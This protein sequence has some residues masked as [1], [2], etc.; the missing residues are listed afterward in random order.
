MD[1]F[2]NWMNMLNGIV[3]GP[4]MIILL[5]GTGLYLTLRLGFV[6]V[7]YL[8][9][10][11]RCVSGKYDD[12]KEQGDVTH[13]QALCSALSATIGTG[14]IAG[15]ATAITLGGP[16]AVFWMWV[17]ALVG[18]AT[19]YT[20]CSLAIRYRIIHEDGS[21]SGGPMYFLE[22]GLNLK[23]LGKCFA[24]FAAA[25]AF[26]AGCTV[27]SNSVA[28]GLLMIM[29]T[30]V[31]DIK[32]SEQIPFL[33]GIV[34]LKP[35]IGLIIAI[36][37]G[38]VIIGGIKRIANVASKIV[39]MMCVVYIVGAMFILFKNIDMV[40]AAF[41]QIF[42]YA[43]NPLATGAGVVGAVIAMTLKSGVARG[44]FS[45]ESGL[46]S[47]PIAHA[48][49]KTHEM[50][51]EGM[52]AMLGP[53]IDTII[54]CTMTALVII[55]SGVWQ[56][57]DNQGNVLYGPNG[58][59]LPMLHTV[60][61]VNMQVV[62]SLD[63]NRQ[64]ILDE[65][66]QPYILPTGAS[67]TASAFEKEIPGFGQWIVVF[68]LVFFAYSSM[69]AWSYYGDRSCEYLLGE[70]SVTPYRYLFCFFAFIGPI[71]GLDL[72]WIIADNLN[73]LMAIPNLIALILLSKV[74]SRETKD[75]IK[76]MK[77]IHDM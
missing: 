39:P 73:A 9:H 6:Q 52:V 67:M 23:W 38:V 64:P 27:Q 59:G 49:A 72:I 77:E 75:Y 2:S 19:K 44:I 51:R 56:V 53:L 11:I 3:W 15:V 30:A 65:S 57:H 24:F 21:A 62:G 50:A 20:S 31:T 1:T 76:R 29:P 12:P 37:V 18:M 71:G 55:I 40:P 22:Q 45:N 32:I 16:G 54:I 47:A 41:G 5:V 58:Q 74:V 61:G 8:R 66:G 70:K 68:G 42:K 36:L 34:M 25:A 33:G 28:D 46:G 35:V 7:R 69:I 63:E 10:A 60:D 4:I 13:F 48:A 43:F 17:T 14:N 26:G